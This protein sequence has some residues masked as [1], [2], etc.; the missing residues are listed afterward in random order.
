MSTP[1]S[2]F[3]SGNVV[4]LKEQDAVTT[5]AQKLGDTVHYSAVLR[6]AC[7][8]SGCSEHEVGEWLL[9]CAV[10]R[11]AAHYER[12]FARDL[13]ADTQELTDEEVGVG[14][15]RKVPKFDYWRIHAASR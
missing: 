10:E 6:K 2:I 1:G 4:E 12:E 8:C 9:K 5:L 13:P 11:G 3:V 14:L 7:R 15:C